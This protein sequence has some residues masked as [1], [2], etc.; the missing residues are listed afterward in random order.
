[1]GSIV[2]Q[3]INHLVKHF[4]QLSPSTCCSS[5]SLTQIDRLS[6]SHVP[7]LTVATHSI[8]NWKASSCLAY[9]VLVIFDSRPQAH[10]HRIE[11]NIISSWFLQQSLHYIWFKSDSVT[12]STCCIG[13]T[14]SNNFT[15]SRQNDQPAL[16]LLGG[17]W[18]GQ[19]LE[20]FHEYLQRDVIG[21]NR[22]TAILWNW[23]QNGLFN[24]NNWY[25][26]CDM[27]G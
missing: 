14:I 26:L 15:S 25:D 7:L 23:E 27:R 24:R 21:E 1:M 19:L 22:G 12:L 10:N 16:R 8:Y 20:M 9:E 4:H 11:W 17:G 13:Y 2:F 3:R 18:D 5:Q 6:L